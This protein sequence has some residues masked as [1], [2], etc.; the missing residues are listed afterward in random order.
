M[1]RLT[2]RQLGSVEKRLLR[3]ESLRAIAASFGVTFQTL[4]YHR[5]RAGAA[6]LRPART[7]GN[8][9]ASWRGGAFVD[10]Y[11]YRMV[12]APERGKAS[13]YAA[14]HVLFAEQ[15]IGRQLR[16]DEVVHHLDGNPSNNAA[17]NLYVCTRSQHKKLHAQLEGLA[18]E[19]VRIGMIRWNGESY[20]RM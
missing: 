17:D 20:C 11:G 6:L 13:K 12:L 14:E 3:G 15:S 9:H 10:R 19:F 4:Q 16:H 2:K 1:V 5:R 7:S 8:A 18:F